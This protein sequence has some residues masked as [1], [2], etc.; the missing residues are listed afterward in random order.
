MVGKHENHA[1]ANAN[2]AEKLEIKMLNDVAHLGTDGVLQ[3]NE[4]AL[5]HLLLQ[6]LAHEPVVLHAGACAHHAC[7]STHVRMVAYVYMYIEFFLPGSF[8]V[9]GSFSMLDA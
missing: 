1:Y 9:H 7:I 3:G 5:A 2:G 6:N 8:M 4:A